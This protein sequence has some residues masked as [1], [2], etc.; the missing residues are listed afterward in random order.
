M[1]Q[2]RGVYGASTLRMCEAG[3]LLD[4]GTKEEVV[5]LGQRAPTL[6]RSKALRPSASA[7]PR[8]PTNAT[9][10]PLPVPRDRAQRYR[11]AL[12]GSA[13]PT[14]PPLLWQHGRA[15]PKAPR[16]TVV[17]QLRPRRRHEYRVRVQLRMYPK[18]AIAGLGRD[19]GTRE[20][21]FVC[22]LPEVSAAATAA[23][24]AALVAR[25]A[26]VLAPME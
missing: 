25:I 15:Q 26:V 4:G 21:T 14:K 7:L 12:P 9:H 8:Y 17:A 1:E 11:Q 5:I 22:I 23:V 13:V 20:A 10:E 24:C 2:S 18:D 16:C 6:P 3:K 19:D